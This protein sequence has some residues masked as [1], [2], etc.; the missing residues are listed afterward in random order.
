[1]NKYGKKTQGV[2]RSIFGK[3][4]H[5]SKKALKSHVIIIILSCY[6]IVGDW[7]CP[8]L[9]ITSKWKSLC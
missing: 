7:E 8:F 3:T 9:Y 6:R 2:T 5:I 1:M 4:I